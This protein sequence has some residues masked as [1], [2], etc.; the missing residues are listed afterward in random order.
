MGMA[1][2]LKSQAV[3]ISDSWRSERCSKAG[4]LEAQLFLQQN[5][6]EK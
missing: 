4:M 2:M 3:A 1:N 5:E 6:E